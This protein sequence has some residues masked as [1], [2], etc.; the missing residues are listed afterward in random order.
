VRAVTARRVFRSWMQATT[1]FRATLLRTTVLTMCLFVAVSCR[2]R[3]I[4][5]EL[6][7]ET[8]VCAMADEMARFDGK[9]VKVRSRVL[10]DR[11]ERSGLVDNHCPDAYV[12]FGWAEDASGTSEL[13]HVLFGPRASR[14]DYIEATFVGRFT[15][16]RQGARLE[17]SRVTDVKVRRQLPPLRR[18]AHPNGS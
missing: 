13:A 8:S 10:S 15:R 3:T 11:I 16:E 6:P 12:A 5:N 9:L 2:Q 4:P 14:D 1:G 17:V 7:Q 18:S